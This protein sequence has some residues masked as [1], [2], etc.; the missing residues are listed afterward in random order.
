MNIQNIQLYLRVIK[1]WNIRILDLY[2]NSIKTFAD[3]IEANDLTLLSI[4]HPVQDLHF[5]SILKQVQKEDS[6]FFFGERPEEE[7]AFLGVDSTID[8][9]INGDDRV[10]KT[11]L[12]VDEVEKNFVNNWK[13]YDL[14]LPLFL[15]GMKFSADSSSGL[16][17]GFSDSDWFIPKFL[18]LVH[19]GKSYLVYNVFDLSQNESIYKNELNKAFMLINTAVS[20]NGNEM[21]NAILST[22]KDD[23]KEKLLWDQNVNEALNRIE[24][25]KVQKIVLSRQIEFELVR[26]G[27]IA[28]IVKKLAAKYPGCY[29]FAYRKNGSIFFG[30]SP[31]KLAKISKGWVEADALAGTTSRSEDPVEDKRLADELLASEKNLE[32]QRVVVSFI[33]NSFTKFCDSVLFD[34]QPI[35]RKLPNIQHL[36]TPIKAR[37]ASPK[38]IFSILEEIHPTPAICGVPWSNALYSIKEMENHSRGLFSGMIGWFNFNNEGEFA[39]AIRSALMKDRNVY[40]FA[41]CGIVRGSDPDNEFEES[42]LK[43]K[44][45]LSLFEN[46]EIYQS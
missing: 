15:G 43:L 30:A 24:S 29:I 28:C 16:W 1:F 20:N 8:L 44:P 12:I 21:D 22:N 11:A 14:S 40:A 32:E 2:I 7:F 46:E 3:H 33:A 10:A 39:V 6:V 36:W 31:E 38:S 34:E 41:G 4:V 26:T 19:K 45:I 42:E 35:I 27:N 23:I 5:S 13:D 37:L 18:F 17:N 9:S 25:G